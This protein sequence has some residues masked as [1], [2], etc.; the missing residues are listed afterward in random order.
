MKILLI[1]SYHYRKGGADAVYFNTAQL[2]QQYGQEVFYF[3]AKYP[4]NV[5]CQ[6]DRFFTTGYD[7]RKLSV[8]KKILA[9]PSFF[10]N[11]DAYYKLL[12]LLDEINPD[13]AHI[14]LFMGGLSSSILL[15]LKKRKIPVVHSVHDYRL[16]CPAYLFTNGKNEVCEKCIDGFYLRCALK[17]CSENSFSQSAMLSID[18]YFRKYFIKPIHHIDRFI[19]VSKFI[20][21][22]HIEFDS[23]YETKADML[24][25]FNPDLNSIIPSEVK[26]KYFL[27]FGRI[28]REKGV[29][30]LIESALKAEITL[31]IVGTGPLSEQFADQRFKNIEF[32]GFR[33][34][35][36]LWSLVR[37]ASFIVVPSEWYENNPLTIVEAYSFGKPVIGA[38]IGGIPEIIEEN[39][40]GYL[41]NPGGKTELEQLLRK[42]DNLSDAEYREISGNARSFAERHFHPDNH[43]NELIGIYEDA[44]KH[45]NNL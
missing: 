4:E 14:H 3:S 9:I 33:N 41:F 37:N 18:A 34:G 36:E 30:T 43:Y 5:A 7:Y 11:K 19:F 42:A 27:Y 6:T 44:V 32:L 15:A 13:L 39:N 23:N 17:R 25:N 38:R 21:E 12:K 20:R 29:L 26:G 8:G 1:N 40:T 2:L 31:K 24:Y 35:E 22:K 10:Y 45:K 16:I 28:S